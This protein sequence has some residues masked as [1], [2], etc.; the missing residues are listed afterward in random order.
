M[1]DPYGTA[2]VAAA[3]TSAT[4]A[5]LA[6]A[7]RKGFEVRHPFAAYRGV[8][9]FFFERSDVFGYAEVGVRSG[10]VL[11][12]SF[13]NGRTNEPIAKGRGCAAARQALAGIDAG[14][15]A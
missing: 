14:E 2:P 1:Q 7:A 6:A 12:F 10:K 5:L 15:W 11:A 9:E 8:D 3:C 4:D 13:R